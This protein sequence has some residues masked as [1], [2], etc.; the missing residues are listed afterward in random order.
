MGT[1]IHTGVGTGFGAGR[2]AAKAPL[3]T[4]RVRMMVARFRRILD[5]AA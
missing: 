2:G 3:A 1:V 4:A 5:T